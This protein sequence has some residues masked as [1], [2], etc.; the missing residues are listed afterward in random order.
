MKNCKA[1]KFDYG[2]SDVTSRYTYDGNKIHSLYY[3]QM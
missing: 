3:D 2:E 1:Q